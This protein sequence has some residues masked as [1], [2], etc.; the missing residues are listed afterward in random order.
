MNKRY[1][2]EGIGSLEHLEGETVSL[3]PS[4]VVASKVVTATI[5]LTFNTT[6]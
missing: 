3:S 2:G 5:Y 4:A 1:V 6:F